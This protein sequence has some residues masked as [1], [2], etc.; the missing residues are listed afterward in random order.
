[1][2]F[3]SYE[4]SRK[5]RVEVV[6]GR[7]VV[8]VADPILGQ[9]LRISADWVVLSTALEPSESAAELARVF[10]V[11]RDRYGFLREADAKWRP[12]D[13]GVDG[14]YAAGIAHSP[15]LAGE[16]LVQAEAAAQRAYER[17]SRPP[18]TTPYT[19]ANVR[20]ALCAR[21]GACVQACVYEARRLDASEDRIVVDPVACRACGACGAA[22]PNGATRL[23]GL[24]E[25]QVMAQLE[26]A[27]LNVPQGR[28]R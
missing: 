16:V 20:H 25:K 10:G 18:R 26:A 17:L 19:V 22:C 14:V 27:L 12:V 11:E 8:T 28:M 1:V 4:L 2:V 21:C 23:E 5:P 13:L 6:D 3:T 7:P 9:D 15:Q 24:G